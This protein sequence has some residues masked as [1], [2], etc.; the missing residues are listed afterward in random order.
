[1]AT[2][3]A[4]LAGRL[5]GKWKHDGGGVWLCD[6]G[7][8]VRRSSALAPRYD[9]DDDTFVTEWWLYGGDGAP[10]R[11]EWVFSAMGGLRLRAEE[12]R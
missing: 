12:R 7:R 2:V 9:G 10:R 3:A 1:M 8:W 6:D 4:T 5:G 11:V